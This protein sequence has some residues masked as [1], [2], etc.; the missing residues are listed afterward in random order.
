[1]LIDSASCRARWLSFADHIRDVTDL[2]PSRRVTWNTGSPHQPE[3][4]PSVPGNCLTLELIP[5]GAGTRVRIVACRE[6]SGTLNQ[7]AL[8]MN[9]RK[10]LSRGI[11]RSLE[12]LAQML[13]GHATG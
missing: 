1:M 13:N 3:G 6:A 9:A 4:A 5:E 2:E 12:Q 8:R 11:E 7:I 10:S